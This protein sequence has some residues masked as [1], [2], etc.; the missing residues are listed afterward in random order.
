MTTVACCRLTSALHL[1]RLDYLGTDRFTDPQPA[2]EGVVLVIPHVSFGAHSCIFQAMLRMQNLRL[3]S[4]TYDDLEAHAMLQWV[5]DD[6]PVFQNLQHL[7][8]K[9]C[10]GLLWFPKLIPYLPALKRLV[11]RIHQCSTKSLFVC[12]QEF[13]KRGLQQ[14]K[15]TFNQPMP[16]H[17]LSCVASALGVRNI[18]LDFKVPTEATLKA[19]VLWE[20]GSQC[21][22]VQDYDY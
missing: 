9:V 3:L 7:T 21:I 11:L 4:F 5:A 6:V 12:L 8:I 18:R 19:Y 1:E 22:R 10:S 14:L 16:V 2:L 13:V 17:E 20:V 15:I